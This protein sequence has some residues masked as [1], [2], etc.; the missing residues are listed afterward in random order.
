MN[1]AFHVYSYFVNNRKVNIYRLFKY[2]DMKICTNNPINFV[3]Y[4]T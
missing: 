1:K 4:A 2:I 3:A